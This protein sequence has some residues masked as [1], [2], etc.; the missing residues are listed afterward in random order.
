[1]NIRKN[2]GEKSKEKRM[3]KVNKLKE[4]KNKKTYYEKLSRRIGNKN[5]KKDGIEILNRNIKERIRNKV[6]LS[7]QLWIQ[8]ACARMRAKLTL[9]QNSNDTS[10]WQAD[11]IARA[12]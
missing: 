4:K 10:I 1:M 11:P 2:R 12:T 9:L 3:Q 7:L 5:A 8:F 6:R